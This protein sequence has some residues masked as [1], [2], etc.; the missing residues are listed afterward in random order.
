MGSL[1]CVV[2]YGSVR[3]NRQGIKAA[4]FVLTKLRE[5]GH[6][7]NF[8]DAKDYDLPL[9]DRMYKEYDPGTAPEPM[10]EIAGILR[11]AEAIVVVSGEYNHS[12]PPAL[13]NLLDHFQT[14]YFWKP[15]G[16]ATYSGGAFAGARVAVHLRAVLGELGMV[17]LPSMFAVSRV[18]KAF[19]DEGRPEDEAYH[20]RIEKFI[21]E[22][23][24]YG[25]ALGAAR[26]K[27]T[28]Y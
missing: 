6:D 13:K 14:E 3:S 23:E 26:K 17:T 10:E 15:A 18:G 16:I 21:D 11:D 19:D 12:T 2:I 25:A 5:R 7:V 9:L 27:G 28:P 22:L 8:V 20:R 24:W 4:R 1:N